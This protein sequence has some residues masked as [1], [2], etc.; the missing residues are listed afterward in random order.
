MAT[1]KERFADKMEFPPAI[2]QP[3]IY[4]LSWENKTAKLQEVWQTYGDDVPEALKRTYR[5]DP[6]SAAKIEQQ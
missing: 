1:N 4:P 3:N 2:E 5:I 6:E